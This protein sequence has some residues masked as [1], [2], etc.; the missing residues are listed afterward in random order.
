[1]YYIQPVFVCAC[2]RWRNE[3]RIDKK[4]K[5]GGGGEIREEQG[6]GEKGD[7][8]ERGKGIG[9]REWDKKRKRMSNKEQVKRKK[10]EH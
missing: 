8:E 4:R 1:M 10:Q 3:E 7:E 5:R 6:I 2:V 9:M